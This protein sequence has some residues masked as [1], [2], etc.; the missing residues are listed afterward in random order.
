MQSRQFLALFSL[1]W[2]VSVTLL[3]AQALQ[4]ILKTVST[5]IEYPNR[6]G[7]IFGTLEEPVSRSPVPVV[8]LIAGSG[9]T[10]RDGNNPMGGTNNSLKM[11]AQ[12]LIARGIAVLRYDKRGVGESAKGS[13]KEGDL[14]FETYITDAI[15][16]IRLMQGEKRFSSVSV[17]GHSEGSLI[18]MI[19]AQK[20]G[21]KAFVSIAGSGVSAGKLLRKQ[22]SKQLPAEI[23]QQTE[24]ILTDLEAGKTSTSAPPAMLAPLFRAS[25]QPYLISWMRYNP[26]VEIQ[27]LSCPVL[28]TQGTT[29]VQASVE[30][31]NLLSAAKPDATLAIIPGM[32]HILKMVGGDVMTQL[33]SYRN[34]T[35]PVSPKLIETVS[36]FLLATTK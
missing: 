21:A 36:T 27:R 18:G 7:S 13:P 5:T 11:L 8:V 35:L 30:D 25:V 6:E 23:M 2:V 15:E 16:M 17:I 24:Q 26:Q 28:I 22:L 4:S 12:Q 33:P 29:D 14:R 34:P 31:A 20:A 1:I 32:N 19:A 10:D 3:P 9:P